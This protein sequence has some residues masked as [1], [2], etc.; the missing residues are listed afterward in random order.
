M[1][2]V[3]E[4]FRRPP[5][6]VLI[7]N[8]DHPFIPLDKANERLL[9]DR[10]FL[11]A[12]TPS[13]MVKRESLFTLSGVACLRLSRRLCRL[14]GGSR[15]TRDIVPDTSE[16]AGGSVGAGDTQLG[17]Q[18]LRFL[19][20]FVSL[21]ESPMPSRERMSSD[22]AEPLV[23]FLAG[24]TRS[25]STVLECELA[26]AV[27]GVGVGEVRYAWQ[28]GIADD[29]LCSCGARFSDCVFWSH[30][31]RLVSPRRQDVVRIADPGS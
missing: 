12:L 31:S 27:G 6:R 16:L 8:V 11:V 26:A 2:S 22:S 3:V 4:H 29:N 13:S 5:Y 1:D 19:G 10:F 15:I 30:V 23:I 14:V 25:G 17:R 24:S 20:S 28:R 21:V 18:S 7:G 9:N